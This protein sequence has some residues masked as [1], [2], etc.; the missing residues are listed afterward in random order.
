[1]VE[2]KNDRLFRDE[3]ENYMTTEFI[4]IKA[5]EVKY[6]SPEVRQIIESAGESGSYAT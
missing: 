4:V 3:N 5:A 1:M 6:V 2:F